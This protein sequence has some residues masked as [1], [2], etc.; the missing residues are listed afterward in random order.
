MGKRSS[1]KKQVEKQFE[2]DNKRFEWD[3]DQAWIN[4]TYKKDAWAVSVHNNEQIRVT[5]NQQAMNEYWDK[6]AMR[7]FDYSNQ[8]EAYNASVKARDEQI[9][10]NKYAQQIATADNTRKYN[11]RVTE[12]DFKNEEL[13]MGLD[14]GKETAAVQKLEIA[15]NIR[16][17]TKEAGMKASELTAMLDSKKAEAVFKKQDAA[18]ESISKQ[19]AI[20]ASGQTGRSARKN[21]QSVLAQQGRAEHM[22]ADMITR[23]GANYELGMEQV[24]NN[25]SAMKDKAAIS[26]T[27]VANDVVQLGKKTGFGQRQL[28]ES[29]KSADNQLSADN[30]QT[31]LKEWSANMAADDRLA[32][33]PVLPPAKT[34]PLEKPKP[35]LLEPKEPPS[36][37]K[38][39][40]I[41]P[42]KGAVS[43][44]PS[45][46]AGFL[47]A[48]SDDRLKY[49]INR[50][51]TSKKGIPVY[52]FKYRH[53]G[54]HGPTYKGTS[55]QD[56][57]QMGLKKA[58]GKLEKEGFYYVDYSKLDVA[59]EKLT[60]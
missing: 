42:I 36:W 30:Q 18:L 59:F 57:L 37:E 4:H 22:L 12:L 20:M 10:Y 31:L 25:L 16:N 45:P 6:E 40:K 54:K 50:V 60:K 46:L 43:Y 28:Q 17:A 3:H 29:L 48:L 21:L 32:P 52:T 1:N 2:Y 9:E 35:Q 58:V 34:P 38:M 7:V 14:F 33:S 55:A 49:D 51:G 13:L 47:S 39:Q 26:Y 41:K 27:K 15:S 56:L 53:D 5:E 11:E 8:V 23:E 19:G 44:G 24:A